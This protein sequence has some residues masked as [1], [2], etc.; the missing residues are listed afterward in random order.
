M[1]IRSQFSHENSKVQSSL[2]SGM[3]TDLVYEPSVWWYEKLLFLV[4]HVKNRK[5][6][7]TLD[8]MEIETDV[9]NFQTSEETEETSDM[10]S[11][12]ILHDTYSKRQKKRK[13]NRDKTSDP[14]MVETIQ[15]LKS[16]ENRFN[17]PQ[18]TLSKTE[19]DIYAKYIANEL[20]EIHDEEI[21]MDAK[22]AINNIIY[23]IKK[24][25]FEVE[26]AKKD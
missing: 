11:A 23:N 26:A 21:F 19:I 1:N 2:K 16:L 14:I 9:E 5:S 8:S 25:L 15:T 4:P 12:S 22:H 18:T 24:K 7:T 13:L 6:K 17:R 3:G 10:S 20:K